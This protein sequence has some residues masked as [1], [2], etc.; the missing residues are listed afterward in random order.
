MR[1]V[2]VDMEVI[3]CAEPPVVTVTVNF[4]VSRPSPVPVTSMGVTDVIIVT[5]VDVKQDLM[6]PTSVV[7]SYLLV[8]S[9]LT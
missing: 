3:P 8:P 7:T 2:A 5:I 1:K 6:Q 9:L 4:V